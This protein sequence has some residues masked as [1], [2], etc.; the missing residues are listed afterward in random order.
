M[1]ENRVYRN[2]RELLEG[3]AERLGENQSGEAGGNVALYPTVVVMLGT[4]AR[5]YTKYIKD[6][7]DDN[8]NNAGFL[9]YVGIERK[10]GGFACTRL[11]DGGRKRQIQWSPAEGEPDEVVSKAIVE[12]LEQDERIFRDKSRIKMEFVMDAVEEEAQAYYDLYLGLK[13]GLHSADLK[14]FYLMLDQKP[15]EKRSV[16]SDDMLQYLLGNRDNP[17]TDSGTTYLLSNY[18]DN[19]SILGENK[20]WQNYRLVADIIL[21]GG[22]RM[23]AGSAEYATNLY[24]GIK[25]ASYALVTKPTDEIAAVSLQALMREMYEQEEARRPAE[26]SDKDIRERLGIK[27]NHGLA[28]AEEIFREKLRRQLPSPEDLRY[29]PFRSERERRE[30]ERAAQI[31]DRMADAC[32]MGVWPLLRQEKYVDVAERFLEDREEMDRLR[33]EIRDLLHGAFSLFEAQMLLPRRELIRQLLQEDLSF[34][35][36]GERADYTEKLHRSA[37]YACK[38]RFY[39]GVKGILEEEFDRF[40]SGVKRYG[41]LYALCEREVRKERIV[42]GDA[43]KS[44]EKT[45][46]G[47]V[48]RYVERHRK[49]DSAGPSFPEVFDARLDQEGLLAAIGDV[50]SDLAREEIFRYDFEK[51]LDFR[52][53]NMTDVNRQIYVTSELQKALE[54]SIRLKNLSNVSMKISCF[55]LIGESADYAGQLA[56]QEG[57]GRD[58]MLFHLNRTDCIEQIEIHNI[59]KP[60]NLHLN[61]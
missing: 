14:T 4:R 19:G 23:G 28:F 17:G 46:I 13:N 59:T 27:A 10:S 25:T 38:R 6:T 24:N 37:M 7:L 5:P 50:F 49:T 57:H 30:M 33:G 51:E 21:L 41:E 16:K 60:E 15:E 42:T 52:M 8:W 11:A 1:A 32:T 22:T 56:R 18:L 43:D 29:L 61:R 44:I 47:E 31:P 40:L 58:F 55:Y 54:G 3:C 53:N 9:R 39:E 20:I 2:G 36:M 12:M 34:E 48:K 45:Y 35:G 26:L